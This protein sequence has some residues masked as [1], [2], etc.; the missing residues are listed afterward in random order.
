MRVFLVAFGLF[1]AGAAFVAG[2]AFIFLV[3]TA[4]LSK[5]EYLTTFARATAYGLTGRPELT[6]REV[7]T[8]Y[9]WNC[10]GKCHGAEPVERS[11]HTAR[12]WETIIQR[13]RT[14]N[15]A[16]I[17]TREVELIAA[18]LKKNYGS[19]VPTVISREGGRYLKRHLWKSDFGESD[20]YVDVI[21][22]P[23]EYFDLTGGGGADRERY[24]I[25]TKTV[26]VVYF[27]THQNKLDPFPLEEMATLKTPG[28]GELRPL[29]WLVTYETGDNHH[30]EGIL[31][32]EKVGHTDSA[33]PADMDGTEEPGG[34][35]E[36]E[37]RDL[38]GQRLRVFSWELPIPAFEGG[39]GGEGGGEGGGGG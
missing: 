19:N 32:F 16:D 3:E 2:V 13:M 37:M 15:G 5:T 31:R 24:E 26:F 21:Y 23:E 1:L 25:D 39:E 27:N 20:L 35:M 9:R 22:T 33:D 17:G 34:T 14:D 6:E 30:R 11:R 7:K 36:L 10:T 18:Y 8:V 12:E 29:D 4:P 38:P 28:G